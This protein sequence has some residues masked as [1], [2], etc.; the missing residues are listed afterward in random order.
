MRARK[1]A[2][3]VGNPL[4]QTAVATEHVGVVVNDGEIRAVKACG[5]VCFCNRHTNAVCNPLS[6]RTGGRFNA[7]GVPEFRVA[8]GLRAKLTEG[9][10]I[11]FVKPKSVEVEQGIIHRRAVSC[12][13][14]KT[15]SVRPT[16]VLWIKLQEVL[17]KGVGD[18]CA[19][20]GKTGVSGFCLF[21]CLS[22]QY[23]DCVDSGL[24]N[25]HLLYLLRWRAYFFRHGNIITYFCFFFKSLND[26]DN[27]I[28][29]AP[30]WEVSVF[31]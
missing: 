7:V 26:K 24:F 8:G 4:F 28:F 15:I 2:S 16:C 23:A 9:R 22:R 29:F 5:K 6:Q 27:R 14:N 25:V 1:G 31:T 10:Q 21:D 3:F 12:R 30:G 20:K 19:A 13:Q 18:G 11:L 17:E